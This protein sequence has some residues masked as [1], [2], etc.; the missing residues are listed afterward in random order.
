MVNNGYTNVNGLK[1]VITYGHEDNRTPRCTRNQTVNSAIMQLLGYVMLIIYYL[2]Y[3]LIE[4]ELNKKFVSAP[5]MA[6]SI[7]HIIIKF[8]FC[9]SYLAKDQLRLSV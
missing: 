5:S 1:A 2:T 7:I 8:I 4:K 3:C 9:R 6:K